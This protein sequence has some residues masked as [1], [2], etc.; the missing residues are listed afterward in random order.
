MDMHAGSFGMQGAPRDRMSAACRAAAACECP[1]AVA[2]VDSVAHAATRD[3]RSLPPSLLP[4][5][6]VL[7]VTYPRYQ[8]KEEVIPTETPPTI[9]DIEL[10]GW[11]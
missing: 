7:V 2:D 4:C 9:A 8:T 3:L 10:R 11:P 5:S 6:L 1:A